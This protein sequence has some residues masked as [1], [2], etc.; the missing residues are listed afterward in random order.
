MTAPARRAAGA[1]PPGQ[2]RRVL[3]PTRLDPVAPAREGEVVRTL[4]GA[5][6][7]TRWQVR[8]P[9][10]S[11]RDL[12]P[13]ERV[14]RDVLDRI[15]REMSTWRADSDLCR[16]NHATAGAWVPLPPDLLAVLDAA[17]S[18]AADSDG[19][20]DP[21]VGAL[22]D[23]W[24]FGPAPRR[25]APPDPAAI[26]AA[27]AR[28]GWRR[29]ALDAAGRRAFQP[30]GIALDL[31]AI[32][33]GHAVDR[34]AETLDAMGFA[35]HLVEV[36]GELRGR[37]AKPDGS[38]WWVAVE[39]P[40]SAASET[41]IALHGLSVATSGDYRRFFDWGGR[42]FA[43]TIDPRSGWAADRPVSVTVVERQCMRADALATALAV[44]GPVAGPAF[45]EAR[46]IAALF[47]ARDGDGLAEI[48]TAALAAM[49][50]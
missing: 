28:T 10:L 35:S 32:A 21:T 9:G 26:A 20:Y 4:A 17:L 27:R 2:A 25:I 29:I 46:G 13:V 7:G 41:L 33:K 37:G 43:H 11:D 16:F 5:T 1:P 34:L 31:S 6:M 15:D 23:L 12:M 50:T 42:R 19:A 45:A 40:P 18:I 22:V 8:V 14:I 49:A 39:R 48:A 44:L 47:L 38:P 30:G 3:V 24:G 36:G